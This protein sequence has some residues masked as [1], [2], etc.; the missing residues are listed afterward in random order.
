M[1]VKSQNLKEQIVTLIKHIKKFMKRK[2]CGFIK[3]SV[4][5]QLERP[6]TLN[7]KFDLEILTYM[8]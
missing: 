6:L 4:L 1:K 5:T 8:F 2:K 3:V 7:N